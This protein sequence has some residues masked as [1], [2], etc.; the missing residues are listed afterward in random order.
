MSKLFSSFKLK[1]LELKNRIVMAPMCMYTAKEDGIATE[2][3]KIHY[4]TRAIGGVGL[5]IQEATGVEPR[6]RISDKDLGVWN[7]SQ[8]ENLKNIV[9]TCKSYGTAMG[10]QLGMQGESVKLKN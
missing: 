6:G 9:E 3:H 4:A 1:N 5:I 7:D 2:W 10:I 8:V